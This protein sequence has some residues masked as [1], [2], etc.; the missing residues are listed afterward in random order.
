MRAQHIARLR[1]CEHQLGKSPDRDRESNVCQMTPQHGACGHPSTKYNMTFLGVVRTSRRKDAAVVVRTV[2][3][4]SGA[5]SAATRRGRSP[6][7]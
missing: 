6:R 1:S 3:Y 4:D 2:A 5:G 7:T